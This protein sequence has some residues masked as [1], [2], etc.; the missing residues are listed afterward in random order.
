MRTGWAIAI[1]D[2]DGDGFPDLYVTQYPQQHP[3]SQQRDGTLPT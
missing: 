3:L 2:Y 1:G